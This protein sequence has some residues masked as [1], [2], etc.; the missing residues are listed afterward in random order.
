M[1]KIGQIISINENE[2]SAKIKDSYDA[3]VIDIKIDNILQLQ[4]MPIVGDVVLYINYDDKIIKIVKI[5][6]IKSSN[7]LRQKDTPLREGESQLTGIL[8][9]YIY[10]NRDGDIKFVDSSLLNEFE[11]TVQ[12]FIAKL[13]EFKIDTYDGINITINK[14]ITI[15]RGENFSVLIDDDGINITHKG[16]KVIINNNDE[17]T[18]EGSKVLLGEGNTGDIVTSGP[19]GTYRFCPVTGSP[20][21]GSTTCKAKG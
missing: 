21:S 20:I 13:K 7:L 18:I 9:Q 8:G 14:D 12:G 11:L 1:F 6:N 17:I 16:A 3:S 2:N 15:S 19:F 10:L 4:I 5:W